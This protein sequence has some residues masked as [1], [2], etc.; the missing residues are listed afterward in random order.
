V[1]TVEP[2][3]GGQKLRGYCLDKVSVIASMIKKTGRDISIAVDGGVKLENAKDVVDAGAN[4][5]VMGTG[6]FRAEDP[7]RVV[8]EIG[9]L[10]G[11]R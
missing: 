10:G 4:V 2:G 5:L 9:A 6:L 7:Q 1:M 3:F 11:C 8:R